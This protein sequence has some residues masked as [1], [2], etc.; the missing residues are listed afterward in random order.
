MTDVSE[1]NKDSFEL[2]LNAIILYAKESN[3]SVEWYYKKLRDIN[4]ETPDGEEPALLLEQLSEWIPGLPLKSGNVVPFFI[5]CLHKYCTKHHQLKCLEE[6]TVHYKAEYTKAQL[7]A[8]YHYEATLKIIT[9][10]LKELESFE[11][12][13][14]LNYKGH[15]CGLYDNIPYD[16]PVI[17]QIRQHTIEY[18]SSRLAPYGA[19]PST[20]PDVRLSRIRLLTKRMHQQLS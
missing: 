9:S 17:E 6:D 10:Y 3:R 16:E 2:S 15:L 8:A 11:N 7:D 4:N 5:H 12:E 19:S 14:Q 1:K 13:A 18:R 20:E